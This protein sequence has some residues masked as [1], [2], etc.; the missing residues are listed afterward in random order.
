MTSLEVRWIAFLTICASNCNYGYSLTYIGIKS[1]FEL[2]RLA[3]H[4]PFG[5]V[6]KLLVD[7]IFINDITPTG[8]AISDGL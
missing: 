8:V 2:Y 3:I 5:R 4:V 7:F 1:D 6:A